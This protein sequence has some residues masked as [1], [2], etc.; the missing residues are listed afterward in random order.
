[1]KQLE[2]QFNLHDRRAH[3]VGSK[4]EGDFFTYLNGILTSYDSSTHTYAVYAIYV[5][6]SIRQ[7]SGTNTPK[8]VLSRLNRD[9]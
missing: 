4:L 9:G 8:V 6:R 1:M 2:L 5:R 3:S 7:D